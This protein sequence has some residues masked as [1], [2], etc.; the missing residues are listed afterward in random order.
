MGMGFRPKEPT[1]QDM[2][3][4]QIVRASRTPGPGEYVIPSTCTNISGGRFGTA[5]SKTGIEMLLYEKKG[6]PGPGAYSMP[7]ISDL[8]KGGRMGKGTPKTDVDWAILRASQTPGPG[9]YALPSS[10]LEARGGVISQSRGKTDVDWQIL[11]S[12][13]IPAPHDYDVNSSWSYLDGLK[14]GCR[15]GAVILGRNSGP[16]KMPAPYAQFSSDNLAG[17]RGAPS[18]D[19]QSAKCPWKDSQAWAK[20]AGSKVARPNSVMETSGTVGADVSRPDM[21]APAS[22]ELNK[23]SAQSTP[24]EVVRDYEE[25]GRAQARI[26]EPHQGAAPTGKNISVTAPWRDVESW[27]KVSK[28]PASAGGTRHMPPPTVSRTRPASASF[29]STKPR[30]QRSS[31]HS[32]VVAPWRDNTAWRI[33]AKEPSA[34]R[35]ILVQEIPAQD[36]TAIETPW[37]VRSWSKGRPSKKKNSKYPG[38]ALLTPMVSA[39]E[40]ASVAGPLAVQQTA[41]T[42]PRPGA[43]REEKL[44]E[45]AAL[46]EQLAFV[47]QSLQQSQRKPELLSPRRALCRCLG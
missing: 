27:A 6:I 14:D 42:M 17:Y 1:I 41:Q 46:K 3:D 29:Q 40:A 23:E 21:S 26:F 19:H 18:A 36:L 31:D 15:R 13:K 10:V 22:P 28:R 37:R 25:Q 20:V 39:L 35:A 30:V 16:A 34:E 47:K 32:K 8:L 7:D 24:N 2:M 43:A 44:V 45:L 11:Q 5:I 9:Q 33:V 12:Q 38:S 4:W